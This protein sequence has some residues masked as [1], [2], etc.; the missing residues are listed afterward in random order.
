MCIR[1]L[2]RERADASA[3]ASQS[4]TTGALKVRVRVATAAL[5]HS[6]DVR[7]H[8]SKLQH[9]KNHA[10]GEQLIR[11]QNSDKAGTTLSVPEPALR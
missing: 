9:P 1:A 11:I 10:A 5:E 6:G 7:V 3:R 8:I 4:G 2:E